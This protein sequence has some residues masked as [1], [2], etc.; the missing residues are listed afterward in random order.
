M[1]SSIKIDEV[2]LAI[3]DFLIEDGRMSCEEIAA[4]IGDI[5]ARAVRYRMN[6]M[7]EHDV[8]Q[9]SAIPDPQ[10]LGLSVIADVYIEVEPGSVFDVGNRLAS[11]DNVVY[12]ACSTGD[13]D[14]SIQVAAHTNSELFAFVADE[15]GNIPG[16]RKT[17]TSITP[18]VLKR[19]G[20]KASALARPV[21]PSGS[22][23]DGNG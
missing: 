5:S 23:S 22:A 18:M 21:S 15:V 13:R 9:V 1:P 14:I 8:I 2:D 17:T 20:Y 3:I 6:A 19:F 12:V 11:Y 16:V 10:A 4:R 7:I